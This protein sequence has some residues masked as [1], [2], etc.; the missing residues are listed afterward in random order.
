[1]PK[2]GGKVAL[3]TG[4]GSGLGQG[5]AEAFIR[6][7]ARVAVNDIDKNRTHATVDRLIELGGE[8]LGV[9]GDVADE[10]M[11]KKMVD[12]TLRKFGRIDI[13]VN[14]A[15]TNIAQEPCLAIDEGKFDKMVEINV[16]AALRLVRLTV[17]KMI[18]R[19]RGSVINIVSI[20]GLRPQPGGLLYS[21]TKAGLIM[22]TRNWA[23]EFGPHGVRVNAIAPGLIQTDFSEFFWKDE[24]YRRR[25]EKTQPIP[26]IGQPEEIGG[27]ALYL[28]SDEA[29]FV[30]GQV[31]VIDGGATL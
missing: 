19:K 22:M 28:A 13:L 1:M 14:N 16:K 12:E 25:L 20:A 30:T 10:A 31:F 18:E 7:G 9:P 15:A 23:Q 24:Q 17:P 27:I 29:S 5:I 2:L 6:E 8:A 21:F 3:V 11:V 4:A 26:R